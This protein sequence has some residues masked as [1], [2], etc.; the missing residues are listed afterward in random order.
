MEYGGER[1]AHW[2]GLTECLADIDVPPR[3]S[4]PRRD[5]DMVPFT[6]ED[7]A[8]VV[9]EAV[10]LLVL[11]RAPMRLGDEGPVISVLR[12]IISHSGGLAVDAVAGARDQAYTWDE[13]GGRLACSTATARRR[14][15]GWARQRG[16][17]DHHD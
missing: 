13:I 15:S 9:G 16:S 11:L 12:S 17:I 14:Y 5:G 8:V 10:T 6:G 7:S 1:A 4:D 3:S 2:M